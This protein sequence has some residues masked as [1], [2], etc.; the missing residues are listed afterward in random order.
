MAAA[1]AAALSGGTVPALAQGFSVYEQGACAMGRAGAG[2][3]APCED[4]SAIFFNPAGLASKMETVGSIGVTAIAP[5]GQF[6]D[7]TSGRVSALNR[8]TLVVPTNYL[9]LPIGRRTVIGAGIFVPYGL[10]SDWPATS[11]ARFLG[12]MSSVRSIYV[13]PTV[14]V[15]LSDKVLVGA[16]LDITHVS[17]E[18]QRRLDLAAVPVP[19]APSGLTFHSLG[20]PDRTDFADVDL[21]GGG[22]H[23][24]AHFGIIVNANDRLSFGGRFLLRQH[25]SISGE[26]SASQIGTG[27]VL[28][29]LQPALPGTPLDSVVAS[30]FTSGHSLSAQSATTTLPLPD[31]LVMGMAVRTSGRSRIFLDYQFTNWSLLDQVT[32]QYQFAPPTVLTESFHDSHGVFVGGEYTL[33]R[34][35]LRGGFAGRSSAAPDQSVTPLLPDAP[36]WLYAAGASVPLTGKIRMDVTYS[37]ASLSDRRGRTTDGGLA[38]PTAAVNNGLYHYNGNLLGISFVLGL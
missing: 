19:G 3:A 31:Q 22:F 2:V 34:V 13:Q 21:Q 15:R 10:T 5:R 14:A 12:Y 1:L 20:V 17:I 33:S 9:A 16:G 6:T 38:V 27:I 37:H 32:I 18:L 36:R 35:V 29:A 26:V 28:P 24:G 30:Q 8:R 11:D 23:A 4:G 25:V 7:D